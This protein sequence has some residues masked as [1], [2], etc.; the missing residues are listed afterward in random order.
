MISHKLHTTDLM[1]NCGCLRNVHAALQKSIHL[2][3]AAV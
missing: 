2:A 3:L 1:W